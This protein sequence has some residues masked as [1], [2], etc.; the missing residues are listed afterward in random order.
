MSMGRFISYI[1]A[2]K[3]I[4]NGYLYHLVR[5]KD[6]ILET[7]SLMSIPVVYEFPKVVPD[8]LHGVPPKREID[9]DFDLFPDTQPISIT[10]CR[11]S[12]AEL[13]KLK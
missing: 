3:M 8:D 5:V 2:R 6:S 13:K 9:F 4:S 12:P 1:K 10:P 11:M 7:P